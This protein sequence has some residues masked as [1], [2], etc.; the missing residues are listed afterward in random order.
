MEDSY[1]KDTAGNACK[2][3]NKEEKTNISDNNHVCIWL[4]LHCK[5]NAS[6]KCMPYTM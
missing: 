2:S 1:L 3:L 4:L 6:I 5:Y